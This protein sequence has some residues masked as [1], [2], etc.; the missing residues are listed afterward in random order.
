MTVSTE[1]VVTPTSSGTQNIS[2]TDRNNTTSVEPAGTQVKMTIPE[3]VDGKV[4][5]GSVLVNLLKPAKKMTFTEH[6]RAAFLPKVVQE[7][8]TVERVDIVFDTYKKDSLKGTTRQKRGVGIQRKVEKQSQVPTNWHSF[9]RID[10]NK[11]EIFCFLSDQIKAEINTSKIVITT[12]EDKVLTSSGINV[13]TV[14]PCN[15]KE[16]DTWVFLHALD[17]SRRSMQRI[18]DAIVVHFFLIAKLGQQEL[19][20]PVCQ[21]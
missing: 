16:S 9:L 8:Q 2:T 5:E 11:E 19:D 6:G 10:E 17:M 18:I 4:L 12:F 7:L 3:K 15:H 1:S 14:S 20:T 13:E 21:V